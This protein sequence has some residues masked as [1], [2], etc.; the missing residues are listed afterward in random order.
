MEGAAIC[1][2]NMVVN[3]PVRIHTP[4]CPVPEFR[5]LI[6]RMRDGDQPA[7]AEFLRTFEP[8]L[9]AT[10]TAW[11][12]HSRSRGLYSA[13][14]ITLAAFE[15]VIKRVRSGCYD[16]PTH[17]KLTSLLF[18]IARRN[19]FHLEAHNNAKRRDRRLNL[20]QDVSAMCI[21]GRIVDPASTVARRELITQAEKLLSKKDFEAY[22]M[23]AEGK[24]WREI[25]DYLGMSPEAARKRLDRTQKELRK[26]FG[27][28]VLRSY[29]L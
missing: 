6:D 5:A 3:D 9:R 29:R 15:T 13:G 20:N 10:V 27:S 19:F 25:G 23:R 18:T 24:S 26:H 4:S 28:S 21:A 2:I 17:E 8:P 12:R 1:V 22:K 16:V 7:I 11:V 14:G